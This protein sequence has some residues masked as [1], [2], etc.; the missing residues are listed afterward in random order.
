M[1]IEELLGQL[2]LEE[3][4]SLL[5]GSAFWYTQAVERLGIRK[6][7]LTDGPHGLRKQV[8]NADHLGLNKSVPAT[9]FPPAA[10]LAASWNEELIYKMGEALG[11]ECRAENVDVLLGPGAN[12]KRSPL[13]G[14]NFEYFSED[15]YLASRLAKAHIT[16]LQSKGVGAS[17]KHFA[18]NNQETRR[19]TVNAK[20]DERT[21]REIY[22]ASFETAIKEGKPWTVMCA[23]NR[24]NGEFGSENK[25][26]LN[27]IQD[28]G[29]VIALI[30]LVAVISII[31]P[32]FRT[33]K[34]FLSL[35]RQSSIN[36]LIAFGMTCVILTGGIDL[37]VGSVLALT[38]AICAS[39]IANGT[40]V[41]IAMI[42]ALV[43]GVLFGII[44]GIFVTKGRL[45][46]FIATLITMTVFRGLTM[47]FMDGKPISNLGDSYLLKFVGKGLIL[48]IPF[49]VI[50][51]ILIFIGFMFILERT[52]FGRKVYATG[53]NEKSAKLA[54]INIDR[55]KIA[56]YAISGL[57]A[58]MAGLILLSRLGSAQP[59]LG[60][61][62]EL[63]A[64]AAVA[65]GGVSMNG[66]RGRIWGTFVGVL[67]IAVLNNGLNI[68]GVSSYYQDV[69]KGLVILI[70][71]LSDRKR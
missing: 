33:V 25:K 34:N 69:V 63:D 57:M 17:I 14:R 66:G 45:Q 35:L 56:T 67:I 55:T 52:T 50:M 3:K 11:I 61:G 24:L 4:C 43:L 60:D 48:N 62:Y 36:G 58:A 18:A 51:F 6:L 10:A 44:S 26:V 12:I 2:T 5:S 68:L 23:Y 54:G 13:C 28:L 53:S 22:L 65:L 7:M 70:A 71:V 49:P 40:P 21:L 42:V 32:E 39:L 64:I 59:T 30:L 41:A 8:E 16:G 46:P 37:S 31:S 29:A 15:P 9:C 20:V 47:I 19:L 27:R 1:A 38:T